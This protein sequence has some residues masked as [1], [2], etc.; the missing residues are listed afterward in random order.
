[1]YSAGKV[2]F[3]VSPYELERTE[4][5]TV[6]I[7]SVEKATGNN[8]SLELTPADFNSLTPTT[9]ELTL[10]DEGL[11]KVNS[12]TDL[13]DATAY[14]YDITF[15]FTTTSDAVSNKTVTSKS[16]VSLFKV[17]SVTKYMLINMIKATPGFTVKNRSDI[18][19]FDDSFKIF[20]LLPDDAYKVIY[21]NEAA[22]G[23]MTGTTRASTFSPNASGLTTIRFG[24]AE[25]S[26]FISS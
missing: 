25:T 7:D 5:Y 13:A 10:S 15:K 4:N 23:G 3:T 19:G 2:S 24:T 14:K 18:D 22:G 9:K 26:K 12:A 1:M 20:S 6:S 8:S 21:I 17:V 11:A 16:T